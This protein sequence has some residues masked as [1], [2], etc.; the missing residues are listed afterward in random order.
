MGISEPF[1][2]RAISYL[3]VKVPLQVWQEQLCPCSWSLLY[4]LC[5]RYQCF[6]VLLHGRSDILIYR[7]TS[8]GEKINT[9]CLLTCA[10]NA[11]AAFNELEKR[12][13]SFAC[14]LK[15]HMLLAHFCTYFCL[16]FAGDVCWLLSKG[17]APSCKSRGGSLLLG[18]R[19]GCYGASHPKVT[20]Q[21]RGKWGLL[22]MAAFWGMVLHHISEAD[23]H[24][25]V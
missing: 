8:A 14:A 13:S 18:R 5:N 9:K 4:S 11:Q 24:L 10:S 23:T 21:C 12:V 16:L 22:D 15:M 1:I 7:V 2:S 17:H 25:D 20:A 3:Q 19:A 6:P